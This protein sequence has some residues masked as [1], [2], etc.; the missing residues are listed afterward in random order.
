MEFDQE[1]SNI[2]IALDGEKAKTKEDE[3]YKMR[4]VDMTN[5]KKQ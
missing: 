2:E 4:K 1:E 3:Y 5:Q